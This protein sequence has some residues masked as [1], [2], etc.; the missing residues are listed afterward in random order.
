[1]DKIKSLNVEQNLLQPD[2]QLY[3][4]TYKNLS[5]LP[6]PQIDSA[7]RHCQ[8]VTRRGSKTFYFGARLLPAAKRR[9]VWAFYSFCRT[10][11]DLVDNNRAAGGVDK[12]FELLDRWENEIR[13]SYAGQV[14]P[15]LPGMQAWS[16]AVSQY[17][18]PLSPALELIEGM[19]MDLR[20]NRYATFDELRL[21]CYRVASTV[22]LI[23]S[24]I[25]GYSDP[26]ALDY[27][28]NLGI[29]MQLTNILRDVGEDAALNRIYIP[30]EDLEAFGYSEEE[31]LRG[32]VNERWIKLMQFQIARARHYY[33]LAWP[34]LKYLDPRCRL[35]ITV[36]ARMYSGI[37]DRIERNGYDVFSQRAYVPT[38]HK[39]G[40]LVKQLL[41]NNPAYV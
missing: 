22:G 27:A 10:T 7:Y 20:Q 3:D 39:L 18:L 23:M 33:K 15:S 13:R 34:G 41:G 2:E 5:G 37:L 19:R 12:S 6:L 11:D 30:R 26:C 8:A 16:H 17:K 4:E 21:Y 38:T 32:E 24:E 40:H 36:A 25:I 35:S 9:A 29:A 28:V 31:L 1:M 14:R